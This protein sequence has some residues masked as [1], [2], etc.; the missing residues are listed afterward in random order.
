MGGKSSAAVTFPDAGGMAAVTCTV[1]VN[2]RLMSAGIVARVV[3]GLA[4]I[5]ASYP[6]TGT[7]TFLQHLAPT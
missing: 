4:A 6:E 7:A 3:D 2:P 5:V 1:V